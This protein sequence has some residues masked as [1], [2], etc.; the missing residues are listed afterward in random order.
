MTVEKRKR[1]N[2]DVVLAVVAVMGLVIVILSGAMAYSLSVAVHFAASNGK[3]LSPGLIALLA[4]SV[5]TALGTAI[6]YVGG[7]LTNSNAHGTQPENPTARQIGEGIATASK[8]S[9]IV[10]EPIG[11]M[12][13]ANWPTVQSPAAVYGQIEQAERDGKT[14]TLDSSYFDDEDNDGIPNR[15]DPDYDPELGKEGRNVVLKAGEDHE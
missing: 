4:G 2:R 1:G 7:L 6:G 15:L 13:P 5:G 3:E 14:D 10:T 11:D 12:S 9:P 8:T